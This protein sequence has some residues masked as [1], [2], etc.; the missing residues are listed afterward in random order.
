MTIQGKLSVYDLDAATAS[1]CAAY[2]AAYQ[3]I[4]KNSFGSDPMP[5][6][7]AGLVSGNYSKGF[8]RVP[9]PGAVIV[10]NFT[11]R[12]KSWIVF[13]GTVLLFNAVL[14]IYLNR[15]IWKVID[16]TVCLIFFVYGIYLLRTKQ[17]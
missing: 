5:E 16:L 8:P 6:K 15:G 13:I 2:Q 14:P 4:N 9:S 3:G 17:F 7:P 1:F 12:N 11:S 10:T